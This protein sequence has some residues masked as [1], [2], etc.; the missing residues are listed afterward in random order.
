MLSV[1]DQHT[2]PSD[3][4]SAIPIHL[5]IISPIHLNV[6]PQGE[7]PMSLQYQRKANPDNKRKVPSVDTD[8]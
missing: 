4:S 7:A 2:F 1:P 5:E 3:V 6:S 8:E